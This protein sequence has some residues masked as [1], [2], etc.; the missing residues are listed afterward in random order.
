MCQAGC[1]GRDSEEYV[2]NFPTSVPRLSADC[3]GIS[4]FLTVGGGK[5]LNNFNNSLVS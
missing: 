1:P 2:H 3:V 4:E 5:A